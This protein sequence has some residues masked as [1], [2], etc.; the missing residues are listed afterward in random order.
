MVHTHTAERHHQAATQTPDSTIYTVGVRKHRQAINT[1]E[2]QH[3]SFTVL[4][5]KLLFWT[6]L[7]MKGCCKNI[8][9]HRLGSGAFSFECY[10]LSI[11]CYIKEIKPLA[12]LCILVIDFDLHSCYLVNLLV[13]T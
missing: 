10:A 8:S 2:T 5:L 4:V 12:S 11:E 7:G 9:Q 3:S 1:G 6:F 13:I